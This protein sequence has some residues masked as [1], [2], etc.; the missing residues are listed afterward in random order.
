MRI[1]TWLSGKFDVKDAGKSGK[2]AYAN[3]PIRKGDV[4]GVH[5]GIVVHESDIERLKLTVSEE[6]LNLDHAMYIHPGF[7]LLH[8]YENGCDPM[9]FINHSCTPNAHVEHGIVMVASRDI[10]P[11]EEISWDYRQTDDV[12]SWE[13]EFKCECGAPDCEGHVRVGPRFRKGPLSSSN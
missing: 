9:C 4:I 2:G 7:L 8:D 6:R 13:Y 5:G 10:Q 1:A 3:Q 12:G 11:G